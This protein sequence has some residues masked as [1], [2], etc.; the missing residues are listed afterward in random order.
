MGLNV[1]PSFDAQNATTALAG[2][3]DSMSQGAPSQKRLREFERRVQTMTGDF[4][5]LRGSMSAC[6]DEKL[7]T[8]R[9]AAPADVP[10]MAIVTSALRE[11]ED[12]NH[13]RIEKFYQAVPVDVASMSDIR[14]ALQAMEYTV[15]KVLEE[16]GTTNLVSPAPRVVAKQLLAAQHDDDIPVPVAVAP[17]V[18]T[19]PVDSTE[20]DD[21]TAVAAVY[22][23]VPG[24]VVRLAGLASAQ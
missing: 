9:P 1:Q 23:P 3:L 21:K 12:R 16:F 6:V 17:D 15:R 22:Q 20:L 5:S 18:N 13:G 7:A 14:S 8:K 24:D 2:R 19:S 10:S 11:M 4:D